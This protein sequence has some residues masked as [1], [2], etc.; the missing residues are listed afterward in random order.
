[1]TDFAARYKAN[2]AR[3]IVARK[4]KSIAYPVRDALITI[5]TNVGNR[6]DY[7]RTCITCQNWNNDLE[8]CGKFDMKP[9]ASVIVDGCEN[10]ADF[11]PL[12]F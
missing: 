9:P 5:I 12:P 7:F 6:S 8:E 4:T 1:M 10:Y 11:D 2:E 3:D